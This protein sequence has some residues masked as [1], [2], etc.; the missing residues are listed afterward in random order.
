MKKRSNR[1]SRLLC[2][3][4]SLILYFS[5]S[6]WPSSAQSQVIGNLRQKYDGMIKSIA[7]KHAVEP[8]LVHSIIDAESNYDAFALSPKGAAGIMQLMPETAKEYGV[9]NLFDP[10]ENI[11][12][13]VK[14]LKDLFA[15]FKGEKKLVLAAYNAGQEAIKKFKG[16]PPYP[17]TR[18]YI[19]KVMASYSKLPRTTEIRKF[20]DSSGNIVF[21][22][23]PYYHLFHN[24][25]K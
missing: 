23:D 8:S 19:K 9:K 7:R 2:L 1:S 25:N 13:G 21:T 18:N 10:R 24:R 16:I 17:E 6:I 22:N 11:E 3:F 14:Y 4:V 20:R 12:G 15:L 5:F